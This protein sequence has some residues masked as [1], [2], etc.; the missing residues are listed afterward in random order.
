M[1][2]FSNIFSCISKHNNL[3]NISYV[4]TKEQST[5]EFGIIKFIISNNTTINK[6]INDETIVSI[7]FNSLKFYKYEI[8]FEFI[9]RFIILSKNRIAILLFGNVN[10][11]LTLHLCDNKC[12]IIFELDNIDSYKTFINSFKA[13]ILLYKMKNNWNKS[14]LNYTIYSPKECII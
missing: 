12:V 9:Y 10:S 6:T 14:V 5:N 2:I 4:E 3:S 1:T 8:P 11:N 13:R 7:T